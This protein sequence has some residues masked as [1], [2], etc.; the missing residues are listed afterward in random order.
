MRRS[1]EG[2]AHRRHLGW[3]FAGTRAF[4]APPLEPP[5]ARP[6]APVGADAEPLAD[7]DPAADGAAVLG[8]AVEGPA[9][10]LVA[11][12]SDE[13]EAL[14][15]EERDELDP[16]QAPSSSASRTRRRV[17]RLTNASIDAARTRARP[18]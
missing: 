4:V 14:L 9:P 12:A 1:S 8:E 6:V 7:D 17:R 3:K 13:V 11:W 2:P 5:P 18:G 15:L 10:V 16:P